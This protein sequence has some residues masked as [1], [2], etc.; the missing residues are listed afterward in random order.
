MYQERYWREMDQLKVHVLYLELYLE[1]TINTDRMINMFLAI[2][3]S[4]SI[5]GWVVWEQLSFVW[6]AIIAFSQ[7]LNAVKPYLP[8]AKRLRSVQSASNELGSIFL[9]MEDRWYEVSEG[10]LSSEQIH[11]LQMNYKERIRQTLQKYLSSSTLPENKKLLEKAKSQ[12]IYYFENFYPS[13]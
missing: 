4:G 11:S 5:A 6:G 10:M 9:T 1:K 2:A 3:S 8:Y 12:A 7:A 13:N